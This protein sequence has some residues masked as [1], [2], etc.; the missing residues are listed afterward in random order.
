MKKDTSFTKFQVFR[1]E[2]I[3]L[4]ITGTGCIKAAIALSFVCALV[5][6]SNQDIFLNIGVCGLYKKEV[7]AGSVYIGNKIMDMATG[8]CFYPDMLYS[9]PFREGT[10]LTSPVLLQSDS[11][12]KSGPKRICLEPC[13]LKQDCLIDMEASGLYQASA[14]YFQPHQMFFVK[15]VSD[16]LDTSGLTPAALTEILLLN[17][18]QITEWINHI[19][20]EFSKN[21][22]L[23]TAREEA[24][25]TKTAKSLLFSAS[26]EQQLFQILKYVKLRDGSFINRLNEIIMK[27]PLPCK[28]KSEGKKY[29]EQIKQQLI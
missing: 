8:R 22:S 10:I 28:S 21:T 2:N 12:I 3:L 24:L 25:I 16:Y 15:I 6:V 11:N 13:L 29:L 14:F 26:M 23:F 17:L 5:P 27:L 18:P 20:G 1:N 7:P 9:H 4:L 19:E